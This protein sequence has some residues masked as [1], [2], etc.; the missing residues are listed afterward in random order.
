[1]DKLNLIITVVIVATIVFVLTK[2]VLLWLL[3][4]QIFFHAERVYTLSLRY[5]GKNKL[6]LLTVRQAFYDGVL[7]SHK[8]HRVYVDKLSSLLET[9]SKELSTSLEFLKK[10]GV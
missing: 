7:G 6:E 4:R 8:V 1:M 9:P 2:I 10:V 5:V 3:R